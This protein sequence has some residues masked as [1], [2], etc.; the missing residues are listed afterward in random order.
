MKAILKYQ[1][2]KTSRIS[3]A[4]NTRPII[5]LCI[6]SS[7]TL[8]NIYLHPVWE[9]SMIRV[10]SS[11]LL[12]VCFHH[13]LIQRFLL[14]T[15]KCVG[16]GHWKTG[17]DWHPIDTDSIDLF[18]KYFLMSFK[19]LIHSVNEFWMAP[20]CWLCSGINDS[21]VSKMVFNFINHTLECETNK[22]SFMWAAEEGQRARSL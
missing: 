19:P 6:Y 10:F 14:T 3:Y 20:I 18:N 12:Y 11:Y 5:W 22:L 21:T 13:K 8:R 15:F 17:L 9:G 4:W 7:Y 16:W 1:D 2:K